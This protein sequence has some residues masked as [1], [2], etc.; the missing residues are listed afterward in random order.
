[1]KNG[2]VISTSCSSSSSLR[3]V[4]VVALPIVNRPGGSSTNTMPVHGSVVVAIGELMSSLALT[5]K[6]RKRP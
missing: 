5:S 3:A 1:M 6:R 2:R 4:S